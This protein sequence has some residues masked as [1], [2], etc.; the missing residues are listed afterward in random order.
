MPKAYGALSDSRAASAA[1]RLAS[2]R[3][4]TGKTGSVFLTAK[5]RTEFGDWKAENPDS[6]T[7]FEQWLDERGYATG[8]NNQVYKK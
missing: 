8:D 2:E 7:Q 6:E 3:K 1:E 5:L 4:P